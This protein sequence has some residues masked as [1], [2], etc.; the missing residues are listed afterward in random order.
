MA[1]LFTKTS[2]KQGF[3]TMN[4]SLFDQFQKMFSPKQLT[5]LSVSLVNGRLKAMSILNDSVHQTW[6]MPG[7]IRNFEPLHQAISDAIHHT[8]FPGTHISILV[9]DQ[10]F[11]S[12]S[13]QLPTMPLTDLLPIRCNDARAFLAPMLQCVQTEVCQLGCLFVTVNGKYAAFVFGTLR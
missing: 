10:R 11:I 1:L 8:Q 7:F 6:E 3:W 5:V 13:F 12:L 9:E 2:P 4:M